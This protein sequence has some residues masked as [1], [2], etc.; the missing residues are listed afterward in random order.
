MNNLT[1]Y[2][3]HL[4]IADHNQNAKKR[5]QFQSKSRNAVNHFNSKQNKNKVLLLSYDLSTRTCSIKTRERTRNKVCH[6][7]IFQATSG[8]HTCLELKQQKEEQINYL[9]KGLFFYSAAKEM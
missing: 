8:Y 6:I 3:L 7:L 9:P 2:V 1:V 4:K 5:N